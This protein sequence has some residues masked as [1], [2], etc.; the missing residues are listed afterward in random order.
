[1]LILTSVDTTHTHKHT[2]Y[3]HP[4]THTCTHIHMVYTHTE[5]QT[6]NT[7]MHIKEISL[8][9]IGVNSCL[10]EDNT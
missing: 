4:Q 1:M 7:L 6:D 3:I 8:K 10:T 2:V 9:K 5:T